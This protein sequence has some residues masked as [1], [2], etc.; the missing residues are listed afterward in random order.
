MLGDVF[1]R[2][3]EMIYDIG[4]M[5]IGFV[6]PPFFDAGKSDGLLIAVLVVFFAIV[7]FSGSVA[8][9]KYRRSKAEHQSLIQSYSEQ[10][11]SL[12]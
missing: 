8:F 2:Q 10:E 9:Y 12:N 7:A 6:H 11:S 5:Q 1:L 3:R 4:N